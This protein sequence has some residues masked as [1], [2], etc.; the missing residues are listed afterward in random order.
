MKEPNELEYILIETRNID[1]NLQPG[2][3]TVV[4]ASNPGVE[5]E[6]MNNKPYAKR[7]SRIPKPWIDQIKWENK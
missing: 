6:L 2:M 4:R 5:I 3:M 7:L 1:F